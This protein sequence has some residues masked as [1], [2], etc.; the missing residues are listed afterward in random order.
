MTVPIVLTSP[1]GSSAASITSLI[2]SDNGQAPSGISLPIVLSLVGGEWQGSFTDTSP[3]AY[4]TAIVVFTING[5][6]AQPASYPLYTNTGASGFY[7]TQKI[8]ETVGQSDPDFWS[9]IDNNSTG[10][11]PARYQSA[12]DRV[13]SEMNSMILMENIVAPI[14][15]SHPHFNMLVKIATDCVLAELYE[16]PRGLREGDKVGGQLAAMRKAAMGKLSD[17]LF[18]NRG[19][20]QR[21]TGYS[22]VG[23]ARARTTPGGT[24]VES[25]PPWPIPQWTGYRFVYGSGWGRNGCW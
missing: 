12:I 3:P 1:D 13:E 4:Y 22:D 2:R 6:Q 18:C 15:M 19:G 23:F 25:R 5:V 24:P 16:F 21:A 11:N 20:F 9:Q 17:L 10:P 14:P 7:T 8:V